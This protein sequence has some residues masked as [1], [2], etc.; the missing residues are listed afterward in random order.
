MNPNSSWVLEDGVWAGR[1]QVVLIAVDC[2]LLLVT[3]VLGSAANLFVVH[4]VRRHK[5]LQTATNALLVNL[6]LVDLLRCV[7]DCPLLLLLVVLRVQGRVDDLGLALCSA[8]LACFSVSCG[9]QLLTV[10]GI[11]LER[12]RA[13]TKPFEGGGGGGERR[14]RVTAWIPF[15]WA[16]PALASGLCARYARDSPVYARCRGVRV[17]ELHTYDSFGRYVLLPA[18]CACLAVI[19]VCYAHIF[20]V[21]RAHGRKIFDKGVFPPPGKKGD[22]KKVKDKEGKGNVDTVSAHEAAKTHL[23]PELK[24]AGETDDSVLRDGG[25]QKTMTPSQTPSTDSVTLVSELCENEPDPPDQAETGQEPTVDAECASTAPCDTQSSSDTHQNAQELEPPQS[26]QEHVPEVLDVEDEETSPGEAQTEHEN[27]PERLDVESNEGSP[28][29]AQSAHENAHDQPHEDGKQKA[30][31]DAPQDI[32]EDT[33]QSVQVSAPQEEEAMGAVCMMPS[34]ANK[35]KANKK[36]ESKLAK[37]SGYIVFT[38]LVFWLPLIG[39]IVLNIFLNRKE[40]PSVKVVNELEVLAVCIACMTSLTNPII[41]A[42]VNPQF[43]NEFYYL[44]NK[45]KVLCAKQ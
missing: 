6:A 30:D 8:Q 1:A 22:E 14:K 28:G 3:L 23:A 5:S 35:E 39:T 17:S 25:A 24:G 36:K 4:A 33:A 12:H 40:V 10:A 13:V 20:M 34:F 19:A 41:Y 18:W 38:F 32:Q 37:R 45:C 21:V 27:A 2:M 29:E 11:S 15:T 31:N 16:A 9:A 26:V 7:T 42:A 44:K 43:R